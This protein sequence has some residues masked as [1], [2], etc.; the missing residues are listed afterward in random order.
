MQYKLTGNSTYYYYWS[1]VGNGAL[2]NKADQPKIK[3]IKVLD[4]WEK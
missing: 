2:E 3:Y 1:Q 4:S